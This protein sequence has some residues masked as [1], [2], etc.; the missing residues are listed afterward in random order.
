[1]DRL[2]GIWLRRIQK[3]GVCGGVEVAWGSEGGNITHLRS[4]IV[5]G[6]G[7]IRAIMFRYSCRLEGGCM[8][9]AAAL[10]YH[11]ARLCGLLSAGTRRE[12][13]V[14]GSFQVVHKKPDQPRD[15]TFPH[16]TGPGLFV[17]LFKSSHSWS[18]LF[19]QLN[20]AQASFR[21]SGW[22]ELLRAW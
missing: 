5:P 1:M 17:L 13:A 6:P 8:P 20:C 10:A 9:R 14:R 21:V 18:R 4:Q 22:L 12:S 19:L 2:C 15:D 16:R 3:S 7:R 11:R